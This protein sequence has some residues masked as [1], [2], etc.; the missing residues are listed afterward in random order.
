MNHEA[1]FE[2]VQRYL[3]EECDIPEESITNDADLFKTLGL[4]SI[5]ALDMVGTLEAQLNVAIDGEELK[6]I[7]TVKDIVDHVVLIAPTA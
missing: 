5:D 3:H 7:R 2:M 4:D 6:Q 1:A